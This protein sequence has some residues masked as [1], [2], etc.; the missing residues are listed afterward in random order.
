MQSSSEDTSEEEEEIDHEDINEEGQEVTDKQN[1]EKD[2]CN[3]II[4]DDDVVVNNSINLLKNI[5][6]AKLET[7]KPHPDTEVKKEM[8]LKKQEVEENKADVISSK[9]SVYVPVNRL[10]EI[11]EAR[12]KLPVTAE[13]QVIMEVINENQVVIIAGETG[14]GKTTQV[15]QFLYEAGYAL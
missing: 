7:K 9:P 5:P 2:D 11:Q 1:I 8:N 15:P 3:E 13:E 12:L 14:S 4:N 10:P 6:I